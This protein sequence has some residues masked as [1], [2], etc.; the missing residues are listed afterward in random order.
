MLLH[1][2]GIEKVISACLLN[3]P[4]NLFPVFGEGAQLL[5]ADV[6]GRGDWAKSDK[7]IHP[8]VKVFWVE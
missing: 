8:L 6:I 7:K 1:P 4:F 2:I 3:G 5:V